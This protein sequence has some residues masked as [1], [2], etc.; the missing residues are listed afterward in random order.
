MNRARSLAFKA[1]RSGT[2]ESEATRRTRLPSGRTST[3]SIFELTP[4][5][6]PS[7]KS[8]QS[9]CVVF[10]PS[11]MGSHRMRSSLST[12]KQPGQSALVVHAVVPFEVQRFATHASL[13]SQI[14]PLLAIEK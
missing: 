13:E 6:L 1:E 9:H 10:C 4:A 5:A 3:A 12:W 2:D 8:D 7:K 11:A 14:V